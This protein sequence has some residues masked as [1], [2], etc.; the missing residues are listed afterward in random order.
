MYKVAAE[1]EAGF[2]E[3]VVM[4]LRQ[5]AQPRPPASRPSRRSRTSAEL[6]ERLRAA[7][8]NHLLGTLRR[9]RLT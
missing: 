8:L 9:S 5:A 4:P 1:R 7:L 6:G 2:F 3:Q